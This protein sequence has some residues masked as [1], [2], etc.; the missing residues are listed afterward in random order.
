MGKQNYNLISTKGR[1]EVTGTLDQAI[2]AAKSMDAELQPS[3]GVTVERASD[4]AT[5]AEV[6]CGSVEI[7]TESV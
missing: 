6:D 5:V 3:F 2:T 1:C 4:G 7:A